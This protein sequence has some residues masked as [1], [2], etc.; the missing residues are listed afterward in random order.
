METVDDFLKTERK[1]SFGGERSTP[2]TPIVMKT[3]E[4]IE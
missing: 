2:V 3:V 4:V 1:M